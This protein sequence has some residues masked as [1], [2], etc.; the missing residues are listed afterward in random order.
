MEELGIFEKR[1]ADDTVDISVTDKSESEM[2]FVV[3]VENEEDNSDDDSQSVSPDEGNL[4]KF[5]TS[6]L[7]PIRSQEPQ[8]TTRPPDAVSG[9]VGN[10]VMQ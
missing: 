6:P 3:D 9:E 8:N 7:S 10:N 2:S 1:T 5:G 4:S